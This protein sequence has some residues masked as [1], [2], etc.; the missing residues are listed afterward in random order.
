MAKKK[1]YIGID[2]GT[3]NC[4]VS[5]IDTE[6]SKPKTEVFRIPQQDS[7]DTI[8]PFDLLP[9]FLFPEKLDPHA[10]IDWQ[11]SYVTG[12]YARLKSNETPDQVIHSAKSWLAHRGID[13]RSKVLPWHSKS[14]PDSNKL[15]PIQASSAYL[16]Y[17]RY[18][19]DQ[20]IAVTDSSAKFNQQ[21]VVV[22]V[23]ASFDNVAQKLTL[24]ACQMA[25]FPSNVK[26]LEEPQ[27]AIYSYLENNGG[28]DKIRELLP[29]LSEKA[30]TILICD[31]GGGTSDFSLIEALPPDKETGKVALRRIAVSDH[32]LLGGDNIDM[33]LAKHLES[34]LEAQGHTIS[35]QEWNSLVAQARKIKEQ[36]LL[37]FDNNT[38]DQNYPI[39]IVSGGSQIFSQ[40]KSASFT[41]NEVISIIHEGFF[42]KCTSD[43]DPSKKPSGLIEIGL[44]YAQ[45]SA[46]TKHLAYFLK[47]R[48]VD[49]ILFN[50]GTVSSEKIQKNIT[51]TIVSWQNQS[52]LRL[53]NPQPYLAVA[54]GASYYCWQSE[55]NLGS[56]IESGTARSVY[57]EIQKQETKTSRRKK[58]KGLLSDAPYVLCIL[59]FG[60]KNDET[61]IL[62]KNLFQLRVN[63]PVQFKPYYSTQREMDK[64]GEL[65]QINDC[66]FQEMPPLQSLIH[67]KGQGPKKTPE[68]IQIAIESQLN[69]VGL[70]QIFCKSKDPEFKAQ[71]D[72][73]E[74]EFNLRV[75]ATNPENEK[76]EILSN[77]LPT[78]L[79]EKANNI[80]SGL[81]PSSNRKADLILKP[82]GL[83]RQWEKALGQKKKDWDITTLRALWDLIGEGI[84]QRY[85]SLD[86]EISWLI[87]AGYTMRPGYGCLGDEAKIC[88]LWLLKELG[89]HFPADKQTREQEMILWR[90]VAGGLSAENQQ[91]LFQDFIPFLKEL[92]NQGI[93]GMRMLASFE[94]IQ[95]K[96]RILTLNLALEGFMTKNKKFQDAYL[97]CIGR[98]LSRI[99]MYTGME[100]VLPSKE[101]IR[102]YDELEKFEWDSKLAPIIHDLFAQAARITGQREIDIDPEFRAK[103]VKK[104]QQ[105]GAEASKIQPIQEYIPIAQKDLSVL[106]GETLPSGLM[107]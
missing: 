26:L 100:T 2:L 62:E 5:Y 60:S 77:I 102:V 20:T 30:Q 36:A 56:L 98:A 16:D 105:T 78:E 11:P 6:E 25:N 21:E 49:A 35:T 4:A 39:S 8:H 34:K 70:M 76:K 93:E 51:E 65:I 63:Q 24:E 27:A 45:E 81:F 104:M 53:E 73:W 97:W 10:E 55:N 96:D 79:I 19:W 7:S 40:A 68:F 82:T 88:T 29:A 3:S 41:G 61:I 75:L 33:T 23:P 12:H 31:I 38:S 14:I 15:S 99:P 44:P 9:S 64:A 85:R 91:S 103:L 48:K 46:I 59:P 69:S 47:G 52:I 13:R 90:R 74:L 94:R 107:L 50:G 106:Y 80:S 92:K 71:R 72:T 87:A 67:L 86:H 42:P 22:T 28:T 37:D 32:I 54:R 43:C 101:V 89:L 57:I 84:S 58:K 17:I 83:L 18:A 66:D 95:E 1:Y